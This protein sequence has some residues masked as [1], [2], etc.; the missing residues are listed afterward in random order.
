[1]LPT[2]STSHVDFNHIY[3]PAEDSFLLLDTLA[4]ASEAQFLT[5]RFGVGVGGRS[6]ADNP[7][8]PSPSPSPVILEVGTGSGVVLAFLTANAR[9]IFGRGDVLT[10]GTDINR[11]ACL[12]TERT[13]WG[14]YGGGG[15]TCL[16]DN[17]KANANANTSKFQFHAVLNADLAA[18]IRP[19]G[20]DLLLFNP[21]Y[22]PTPELPQLPTSSSSRASSHGGEPS[23]AFRA[24]FEQDSNMLA[25]SYA[26]G[27]DGMEVAGRL[28]EQLPDLLS[29]GRGVAYVLFCKQNRPDEIVRRIREW[30]PEWAVDVVGRSGKTAGWEKLQVLRIW[31][32]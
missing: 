22:V 6:V 2:P 21:P 30:G 16:G 9:E 19:G 18:P 27:A 23:V 31:R 3:E 8:P 4:S 10:L 24:K 11:H 5:H 1:M 25:L 32:G 7:P 13:V 12:A 15:G 20:V 29:S 17:E 28:L 14:A 26:G